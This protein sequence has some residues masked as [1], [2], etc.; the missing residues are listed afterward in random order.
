MASPL[1]Y[2]VEI[3]ISGKILI[4]LRARANSVAVKSRTA[5]P[6]FRGRRPVVI[7]RRVNPRYNSR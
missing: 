2:K 1:R 7:K 4:V 5:G 3:L 6:A